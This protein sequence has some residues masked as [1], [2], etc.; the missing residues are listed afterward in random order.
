MSSWLLVFV[1]VALFFIVSGF[2]FVGCILQTG[3]LGGDKP[4][5]FTKYSDTDVLGNPSIVAYWPLNEPSPPDDSVKLTAHD[6][7]GAHDGEYKHKGNAPGLF[8]CPGFQVA[9]GLDTAEAI[10]FLS[11]GTESLLPGDAVQPGND[12]K[13][14]T[15]G[16]Q[17]DGGFVTV[18]AAAAINPP[19]FTVE[20][21]VRPEWSAAASPAARGIVT[22]QSAG[23]GTSGFI[24]WV[25]EAGNWEA[26]INDGTSSGVATATAGMAAL[27]AVTHLVLTFDGT[28]AALFVNGA[29]AA[30]PSPLPAGSTYSPNTSKP[31][32]IG[33]AFGFLPDR[34][35]GGPNAAFPL[36]PFNGTI[37]DVAIYNAVLSDADIKQ[38]FDDGSGKT[39]VPAG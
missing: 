10:G 9:P 35:P 23:T 33:A 15:T 30:G 13:I 32:I 5:P 8:P 34:T 12:P 20:A 6:A 11:L 1:P 4:V 25:N 19:V 2:G 3:G 26:L 31:L 14:L 24:L 39:T 36:F 17:V 28:N 27:K 38:H 16:M 37:Q 21:W 7:L 22:S 18:P 29:Q